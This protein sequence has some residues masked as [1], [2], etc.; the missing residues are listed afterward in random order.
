MCISCLATTY[1][2]SPTIALWLP[3]NRYLLPRLIIVASRLRLPSNVAMCRPTQMIQAGKPVSRGRCVISA[4]ADDLPIVAIVPL[5][6]Y[7]NGLTPARFPLRSALM[8]LPTCLPP[9]MAG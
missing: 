6:E 1:G 4:T 2:V 7:L 9:W 8:S 5:S 3:L